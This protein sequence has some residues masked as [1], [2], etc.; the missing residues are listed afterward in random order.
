MGFGHRVYKNFDPRAKVMKQSA[1]EVLGLLGIEDNPTLQVAKELER[2]ALEDDYFIE[3]KLYPNVDFYSG[4]ILD[5]IGF[6]TSMFTPIF[7]LGAH[8]RL[9]LAVEGDARGPAAQDRP[10]AAA[11]HR[12]DLPRLRGCRGPLRPESASLGRVRAEAARLGLDI[13]PVRL[14]EGTRTAE[15]AAR[16]C[17]CAVDQIVKS[18]VFRATGSDRHVLFLTAGGNRVSPGRAAALAGVALEK[19]DAASIR[20]H[21]GFAIGGV[22]PLGHLR[23]IETWLDPKLLD[24]S[25][26]LGRGGNAAPRVLRRAGR[27]RRGDRSHGRRLHRLIAARTERAA[28]RPGGSPPRPRSSIAR[29]PAARC[30]AAAS[31]SKSSASTAGA[32]RSAVQSSNRNSGTARVPVTRLTRVAVSIRTIRRTIHAVS[33]LAS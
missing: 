29:S 22:A 28:R 16:A 10:A 27:A 7:A 13:A 33:A 6:P 4:I 14:A 30:R 17:G 12:Q 18:I 19:A 8:R 32:M 3:K 25:G 1:D 11:L 31:A 15:D 20:A 5:A 23:A 21:T 9:D 24:L 26:G 2:I